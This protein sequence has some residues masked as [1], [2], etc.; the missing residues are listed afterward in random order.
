VNVLVALAIELG[1]GP[2]SRRGRV[3]QGLTGPTATLNLATPLES[4]ARLVVIGLIWLRTFL[5]GT[6]H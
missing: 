1:G 2:N 3:N 4:V 6:L 5:V